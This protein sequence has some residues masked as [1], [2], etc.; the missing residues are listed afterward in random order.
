V[1]PA[2][3]RRF[4]RLRDVER[5]PIVRGGLD[6]LTGAGVIIVIV[7][8]GIDF[9]HADFT[10]VDTSNRP[11]SRLLYLWDTTEP[12]SAKPATCPVPVQYPNGVPI[13]RI[14]T[15]DELTAELGQARSTERVGAQD[16]NGHGTKC[17]GIAGGNGRRSRGDFAGVAPRADLIGVRLSAGG[18]DDGRVPNMYLLNAICDWVA[19]VAQGRP[20]VISCSFGGQ[21]GGRDGMRVAERVLGSHFADQ[22]VGRALCIAAGNE[23]TL[24]IHTGFRLASG[25]ERTL[26]WPAGEKQGWCEVFAGTA[27]GRAFEIIPGVGARSLGRTRSPFTQQWSEQFELTPGEGQIAVR[28]KSNAELEIDAYIGFGDKDGAEFRRGFEQASPQ[29]QI[30]SPGCALAAIT[31]GSYDWRGDDEGQD[32]CRQ[33]LVIGRLS[34]YSNPGPLRFGDVIKPDIVAPGYA[35][36]AAASDDLSVRTLDGY[37]H[38][39]GTSAATP[40]VAGVIALML[41]KNP[42]LTVGEIRALIHRH[43]TVDDLTGDVPNPDWGYGKLDLAAVQ[44]ILQAVP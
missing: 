25:E 39:D 12:P 10:T 9:R 33:E 1:P 23:R 22:A 36:H 38:M 44:R 20:F 4:E 43:A 13:G 34:C 41:E 2:P 32:A 17:A 24:P 35:H 30:G 40:Y 31:V 3:Q 6:G 5:H 28:N 19:E 16:L 15:R 8:S 37:A 27:D 11:T 7:D 18:P 21:N 14:Y 26:R 29:R 42:R